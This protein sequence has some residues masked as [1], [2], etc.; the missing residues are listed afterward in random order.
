MD[1]YSAS[2]RHAPLIPRSALQ[3]HGIKRV[4]G[5]SWYTEHR[6]RLWIH[7]ASR[8]PDAA[9][10]DALRAEY[11]HHTDRPFPS[12]YPT[13]C[14]LGCVDVL[15]C[16]DLTTYRR[17]RLASVGED[18]ECEFVMLVER[19]RLLSLPLSM[20]G[21]HKLWRLEKRDLAAAERQ[22]VLNK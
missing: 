6:G 9:E 16:M 17:E 18:S 12:D 20:S 19:P 22:L 5:R 3:V 1:S 7:A 2:S 8:T 14:L 13:S 15:D 4:E 21:D 10:I 11:A